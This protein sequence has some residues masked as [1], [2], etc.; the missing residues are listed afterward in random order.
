KIPPCVFKWKNSKGYTIPPDKRLAADGR[1]LQTVHRKEKFDKLEEVLSIAEQK[2]SEDVE[3][4]RGAGIKTNVDK[5]D[6]EARERDEIRHDKRKERQHDRNLSRAAPE[7]RSKPQT[8]ENGDISEVIALV[9]PNPRVSNEVQYDQ[10]LFN[11][12]Q[13]MDSGFAGGQDEIYNIYD[14]AWKGGKDTDQSTY[15][16]NKHLD[17]SCMVMTS[18]PG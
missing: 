14:E 11:Q 13:G 17:K 12:F 16:P 9:V 6:G 15:R 4:E 10:R 1:G 3:V 5:E 7:K 2:A 8:N 18:K